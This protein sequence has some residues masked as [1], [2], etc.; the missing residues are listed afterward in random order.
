MTALKTIGVL[1]AFGVIFAIDM[2][3]LKAEAN[4]KYYAVYYSVLAAGFLLG[5]LEVFKLIPDYNADLLTL[6]EKLTGKG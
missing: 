4:K 2:P 3:K 6:Y 1:F 5:M